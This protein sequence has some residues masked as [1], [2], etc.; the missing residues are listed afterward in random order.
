MGKN[1]KIYRNH[2]VLTLIFEEHDE[3]L[4]EFIKY[5]KTIKN[6]SIESV[7]LDDISFKL[8]YASKNYLNMVEK[9]FVDNYINLKKEKKLYKQDSIIYKVLNKKY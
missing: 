9:Q 6:I 1:R 3:L 7:G 4:A 2:C 5:S 8:I